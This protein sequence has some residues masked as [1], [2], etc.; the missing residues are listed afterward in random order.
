MCNYCN[1]EYFVRIKKY[2]KPILVPLTHAEELQNELVNL[3][4]IDYLQI[5]IKYCPMCR[6]KKGE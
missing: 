2:M 6:R 5:P 1:A 3:T 4:G